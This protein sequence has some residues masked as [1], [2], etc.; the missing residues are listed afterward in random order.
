[1]GLR[2]G[3]A[4]LIGRHAEV[5]RLER[6]LDAVGDGGPVVLLV[7]GEAGVGKT[8]LLQELAARARSR[9]FRVA[10]GRCVDGGETAWPLA[11]LREIVGG[12]VDELDGETLDLVIGSARGVLAGLVPELGGEMAPDSTVSTDRLCQLVV[13]M[14]Q[15]LTQRGPLV[16]IFEDLHWADA[17]TLT[18]VA[19]FARVGRLGPVLVVGSFRSDELHRRHPLRPVV[20]E[21][22]RGDRCERIDLRPFDAKGT[23][24]LVD[25]LGDTDR[26]FAQEVHRRSGG[27]AFF[28]EELVAA[29][30]SGLAGLPDTLRDVILARADPLDDAATTVLGVLAAAHSTTPEVL[31]AVCALDDAELRVTLEVLFATALIVPVGDEVWFRHELAR[32]VF[33]QATVPGERA[34]LHA[35]LAETLQTLRPDR[36]GEIARHW[37]AVPDPARTMAASAAAARQALR[38]GAAAEAEAHLGRALELWGNVDDPTALAGCDHAALLV[39]TAVA[40]KHARH[41]DRAIELD[42]RAVAELADI[43]PMREAQVWLELR[44]LYR[45]TFR[46]DDCANAV[47]R[48]L[49]L[50]PPTPPTSARAEALAHAALGECYA[51]RSEPAMELARQAVAVADAVDDAEIR[52]YAHNALTA[53]MQTTSED[54]ETA[55]AEARATVAMCGPDVSPERVLD[56]YNGLANHLFTCGRF[57]EIAVV[58]ERAVDL[59]RSTGLGGVRA[60][61]L[62]QWWIQSMVVLGRWDDAER[63]VGDLGDLL[64]HP[65]EAGGLASVWG[66]ALIRQG[67]LDEARPLVEAIRAALQ[68]GKWDPDHSQ[69]SF[70]VV[71]FDAAER[72]YEQAAAIVDDQLAVSPGNDVDLSI[73]GAGVAALADFAATPQ[74]AGDSG[75]VDWAKATATRWI[76]RLE[77]DERRGWTYAVAPLVRDESLAELARLHGHPEPDSWARLAAGWASFG[78]RYN[79]AYARFRFAEALLAGSPGRTSTARHAAAI[80]LSMARPVAVQLHAAPLLADIEGLAQRAH[81][82]SFGD[83]AAGRSSPPLEASRHHLGLT[84]RESEVLALI[85]RGYTN[86]QIGKELFISTKTASVHV[87]NILRK[88]GVTN[89]VEAA[90]IAARGAAR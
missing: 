6:A 46:W 41:L 64:D 9:R 38:A 78:M 79:E 21:L 56:A 83:T 5:A 40:A 13:A 7:A 84:S 16:L 51:N 44:D 63:L 69:W 18:L 66:A 43:D 53:A 36:L 74:A 2:A 65:G 27:N 52:V 11:P 22:G 23:A 1:M 77:S 76:K 17:T 70:V 20:A 25:A 89:R 31:A 19:L 3:S 26:V 71:M 15:R 42:L 73:I 85:S 60:A 48:A 86:G 87:S 28:V 32:E 49:A 14:I 30:A 58:A 35:R 34:R 45:F 61:W 24:E 33:D 88:L 90:T 54:P 50:I 55:L 57:A 72:R 81:L 67:R 62:A 12:L 47:A 29:H 82:A 8:R 39:E 59:A 10:M 80:E 4:V 37:A 75:A 68:R